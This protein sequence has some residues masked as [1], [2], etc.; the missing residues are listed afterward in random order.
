MKNEI[1]KLVTSTAW[2]VKLLHNSYD[3]S[4]IEDDKKL[5]KLIDEELDTCA[6]QIVTLLMNSSQ[7]CTGC[8][9]SLKYCDTCERMLQS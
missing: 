7:T 6:E 4:L 3:V 2:E 5:H 1:R 9:R 8:G